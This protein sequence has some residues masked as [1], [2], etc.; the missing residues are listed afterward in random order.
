MIRICGPGQTFRRLDGPGYTALAFTARSVHGSTGLALLLGTGGTL[1]LAGAVRD[2]LVW[3]CARHLVTWRAISWLYR[4][5]A[6]NYHDLIVRAWRGEDV[7]L[8]RR[9]IRNASASDFSRFAEGAGYV[10]PDVVRAEIEI[11]LLIRGHVAGTSS[12]RR[13]V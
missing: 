11:A 5:P 2:V 13:G 4:T 8:E 7:D 3:H 12:A 6:G 9:P 1:D 10:V